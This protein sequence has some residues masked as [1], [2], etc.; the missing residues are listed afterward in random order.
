M[1]TITVTVNNQFRLV[2]ASREEARSWARFYAGMGYS[3]V[4]VVV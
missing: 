3:S 2:C 1:L 4:T